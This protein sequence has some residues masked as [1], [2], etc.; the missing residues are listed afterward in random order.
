MSVIC[1]AMLICGMPEDEA[2]REVNDHLRAADH[3][4]Q[5]TFASIDMGGAGGTKHFTGDVY[6]AAFNHLPGGWVRL[7]VVQ[8]E[9]L[10]PD[11]AIYW[12]HDYERGGDA[13][14]WTITQLRAEMGR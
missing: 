4:R 3:V 2:I 13:R 9:W 6:A 14:S 8:T 11:D 5:Q 12:E 7:A 10:V 1:D